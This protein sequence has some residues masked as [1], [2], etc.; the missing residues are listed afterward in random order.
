M[1]ENIKDVSINENKLVLL[2][3]HINWGE[4]GPEDWA[5]IRWEIYDNFTV[6]IYKTFGLEEDEIHNMNININS[7]T[8]KIINEKINLAK[9]NDTNIEAF[10]GSAWKIV[11]FENGHEIWNRKVGYIYGIK[12]LEE[13]AEI[14]NGF[15][16]LYRRDLI[17]F[18]NN[19]FNYTRD[20][21]SRLTKETLNDILKKINSHSYILDNRFYTY[22][23]REMLEKEIKNYIENDLLIDAFVDIYHYINA[24]TWINLSSIPEN[25]NIKEII[26]TNN[27]YKEDGIICE[28]EK[29]KIIEM[30]RLL[31]SGMEYAEEFE[32]VDE[33]SKIFEGIDLD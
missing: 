32:P 24:D 13:I 20:D 22:G 3:E 2:F 15:M 12:P 14:L 21:S 6:K 17:K 16:K 11:Q 26:I 25:L 19:K 18:I 31:R 9:E 5:N 7:Q 4:I 29:N 23:K 28:Q 10:D 33:L 30:L 8:Y 27:E 1:S